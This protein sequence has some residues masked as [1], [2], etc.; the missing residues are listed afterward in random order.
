MK[1]I[2]IIISLLF[3]SFLFSACLKMPRADFTFQPTFPEA[4]ETIIFFNQSE[5]ALRFDWNFGNGTSSQ[6]EEPTVVYD[7]PGDYV[8]ELVA[9][10]GLRSSTKTLTIT[11]F[12]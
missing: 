3:V 12:P 9:R 8:V 6:E 2:R 10:N 11:V 5:D 4:G 7:E 1:K